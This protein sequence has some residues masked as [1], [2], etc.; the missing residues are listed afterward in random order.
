[1]IIVDFTIKEFLGMMIFFPFLVYFTLIIF[2]GIGIFRDIFF[3]S[4]RRRR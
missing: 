4:D 3:T 1:M 2:D